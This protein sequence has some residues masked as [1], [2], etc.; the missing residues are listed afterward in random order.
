MS[1]VCSGAAALSAVKI[2]VPPQMHRPNR[3]TYRPV[4]IFEKCQISADISVLAIYRSTT[5][6][7]I[8]FDVIQ[9]NLVGF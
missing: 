6:L 2:K 3:K 9:S 5:S 1:T 4:L 8:S 7:V